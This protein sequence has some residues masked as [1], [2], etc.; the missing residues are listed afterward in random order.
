MLCTVYILIYMYVYIF[1]FIY[2]R[3][4]VHVYVIICGASSCFDDVVCGQMC[5]LHFFYWETQ[6]ESCRNS[7]AV[8]SKDAAKLHLV[9]SF[10]EHFN[11]ITHQTSS[12]HKTFQ[13]SWFLRVFILAT[14]TQTRPGHSQALYKKRGFKFS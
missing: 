1:F 14:L 7:S 13:T 4:R 11:Q 9:A 6:S 3:R 5:S 10:A 8:F 2:I 12:S